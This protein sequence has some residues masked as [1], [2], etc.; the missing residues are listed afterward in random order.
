MP[1]RACFAVF[2]LLSTLLGAELSAQA[3]RATVTDEGTGAPVAGAMVRVQGDS[4]VL[5]RAGFSDARG[6]V[7]LPLR[8]P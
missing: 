3:V 1:R 5:V 8:D 4:G 7:V 2:I 6:T